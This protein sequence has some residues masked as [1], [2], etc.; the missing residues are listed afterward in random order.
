MVARSFRLL[1]ICSCLGLQFQLSSVKLKFERFRASQLVVDK[2]VKPVKA[3]VVVP[4][5]VL[6]TELLPLVIKVGHI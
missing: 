4:G 3:S 5:V 6:L 2:L 1:F